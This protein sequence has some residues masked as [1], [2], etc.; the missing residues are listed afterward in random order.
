MSLANCMNVPEWESFYDH[1]RPTW[2]VNRIERTRKK[3]ESPVSLMVF[4]IYIHHKWVAMNGDVV[5]GSFAFNGCMWCH[6]DGVIYNFS[7]SYNKPAK[8]LKTHAI[9]MKEKSTKQTRKGYKWRSLKQLILFLL[10]RHATQ[11]IPPISRSAQINW[12][13]KQEN[14]KFYF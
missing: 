7:S 3:K 8:I 6:G 13:P 2:Q 9:T 14:H 4:Y 12:M 11:A 1:N 5:V 10:H